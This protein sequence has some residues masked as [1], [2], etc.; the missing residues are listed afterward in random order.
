MR[1]LASSQKDTVFVDVGA[2]VGQHSLFMSR[3][4]RNIYSFEPFDAVREKLVSNME[5]NGITNI[6]VHNVG[7]G[8]RTECLPYVAPQSVNMGTGYFVQDGGDDDGLKLQI[9]KGDEYFQDKGLENVSLVK[10]DVE[11]F[12]KN[13]LLGLQETIHRDK[14]CIIME[15]SRRTRSSF[16]DENELRSLLPPGYK[17]REIMTERPLGVLFCRNNYAFADFKFNKVGV[18]LLLTP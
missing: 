12:E 18:D 13:V 16:S 7:L 6:S 4:C 10:I 1:D 5:L 3:Y 11:G 9:V 17:I 15:Y 8:N 14:P 2:N